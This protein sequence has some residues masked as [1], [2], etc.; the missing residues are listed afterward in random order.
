MAFKLSPETVADWLRYLK[1]SENPLN[2][3]LPHEKELV[4]LLHVGLNREQEFRSSFELLTLVFPYFALTLSHSDLWSPLLMDALLMAQDIKDNELQVTL[5]RW[6]GETY[7]KTGQ[8]QSA[9]RAFNT[10]LERAEAGQIDDMMVAMYTGIFKLQWFD[11]DQ[12]VTK[13]L[14]RQALDA[15]ARVNDTGLRADLH[16][17]LASAYVRLRKTAVALGYGQTAF[18]YWYVMRN[19]S[20]LGRAAYT[21][22]AVYT[23]MTQITEDKRFLDRAINY[24]E[25]ARDELSHTDDVW[26][27]PLLAYEEAGIY[28]QLEDYEAAASWF[29]QSLNEALNIN[30]PHY[31]VIAHHGLGLAQAKLRLFAAGRRNLLTALK[32]WDDFNNAYE[33]GSVLVGLADLELHAGN[34]EKARSYLYTGLDVARCVADETMRQFLVEQ[35]NDIER[36]LAS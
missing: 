17:A 2:R 33:K 20:G 15:A 18:A 11:L 3:L 8:H 12:D 23:H 10:G 34:K 29:E 25:I 16:D 26:Q 30:S 4:S 21:L 31:V 32:R 9:S 28:Y 27:Y 6:W 14:I 22:A 24:L 7:L 36:L 5:F 1:K 35:F 19:H 13:P